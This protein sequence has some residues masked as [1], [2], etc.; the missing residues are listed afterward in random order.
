ML[1]NLDGR[2]F[3]VLRL[4]PQAVEKIEESNK[5][6]E[7]TQ[8]QVIVLQKQIAKLQTELFNARQKSKRLV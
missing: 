6:R 2:N 4:V 8:D 5:I 3:G 7:Q 1:A